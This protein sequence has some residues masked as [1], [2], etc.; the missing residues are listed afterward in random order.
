M[1]SLTSRER[2]GS[3]RRATERERRSVVAGMGRRVQREAISVSASNPKPTPKPVAAPALRLAGPFNG[4]ETI[5][6]ENHPLAKHTWYKIG[7]P[8][9]YFLRPRS[10]EE[11]Q[12]VVARC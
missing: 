6:T 3:S 7:G 10:V 1:S 8:A 9:R 11:L 2:R 4:L 12:A 5:V